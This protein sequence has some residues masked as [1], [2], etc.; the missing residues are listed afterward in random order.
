VVEEDPDANFDLRVLVK[1]GK[2]GGASALLLGHG[3]SASALELS[4]SATA[5]K[6]SRVRG[7]Q[8]NTLATVTRGYVAP[9]MQGS[10][11]VLQWRS[12]ELRVIYNQQT[13]LRQ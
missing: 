2:G 1:G 4:L 7:A 13:L 5:L 9:A 3:T 10:P 6:L 12:G 11:L 8:R